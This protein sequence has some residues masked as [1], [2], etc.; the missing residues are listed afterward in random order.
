M[1]VQMPRKDGIQASVDLF[2]IYPHQKDRP[3]IIALTANATAG[4]KEKCMNAGMTS[5]IPKPILPDELARALKSVVPL[6][7]RVP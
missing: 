2:E 5:H 3:T 4:D 6:K 1:D 7:K